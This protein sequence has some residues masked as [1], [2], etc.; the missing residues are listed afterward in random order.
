M[1]RMKSAILGAA[2]AV[3]VTAGALGAQGVPPDRATVVKVSGPVSLPGVTLPAGEYLFRLADSQATRNIV[4][5]YDKDRTKIFATILAIPAQRTERSDDAVITFKETP[6]D[7]PPAVHYWY[8][9]GETSGQEFAYPKAQAMQIA[10]ASGESVLAVDAASGDFDAMTS[11]EITRVEPGTARAEQPAQPQTEQSAAQAPAE[12]PAPT[13]AEQQAAPQSSERAT[14][15]APAAEQQAAPAA[16]ERATEPRE[17]QPREQTS[18]ATG[19]TSQPR[20]GETGAAP[21]TGTG[22]AGADRSRATGTSGELPKTASEL[23]LVGL[24]GFLALG[25][26]FAARGLRRRLIV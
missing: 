21:M 14:T 16:T 15:P 13:A 2:A 17:Q 8:Y 3:A 23:P 10:A 20:A 26:A 7:R 22:N 24:V 4:Q 11:G 9:A 19:A 18:A 12:T 25:A 1:G 6:S 5:I